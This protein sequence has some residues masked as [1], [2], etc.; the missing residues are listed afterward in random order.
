MR[1]RK[2]SVG[3]TRLIL[4]VL[5]T[6]AWAAPKYKVL[7]TFTGGSD[8][9]NPYAGPI[10]DAS[11]NL[12]GTTF[13]GGMAGCYGGNGCGVV[14][15][16]TPSGSG[17]TE[18]VLYAFSGDTDG[19]NPEASLIFDSARNLYGVTNFG[20]VLGGTCNPYG[21]GIAFELTPTSNGWTETVLYDLTETTGQNPVDGLIFDTSGN[22]WG[23]G[24]SGGRYNVGAVFELSQM[25]EVWNATTAF[26][27][28]GHDNAGIE[29]IAGM[30]LDGGGN[31]YGTTSAGG[32]HNGG[33]VFEVVHDTKKVKVLYD[34][35]CDGS[36]GKCKNGDGGHP[37]AGLVFDKKDNLYGTTRSGG[38]HGYGTVFKLAPSSGGVWKE[39]V[40]YSFSGGS[41]GANP[42]AGLVFTLPNKLYGTTES[43]GSKTAC[44][45]FGCGTVFELTP[46]SSGQWKE[47]ILHRFNGSDGREP[48]LGSLATDAAG[49]LYGT[50]DAG[51]K[52]GCFGGYGCGVVFEITP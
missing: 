22:L 18:K 52:A 1:C 50:A 47:T 38:A 32:L 41:D 13:S 24:G 45:G 48:Y 8:G 4:A 23:T 25:G 3:L 44:E 43:G 6:G 33:A 11:R 51:G 16:L 37:W 19:Q 27:F 34:F 7:Y 15:R 10:L 2:I 42:Y 12:Y 49:H 9:A 20:G 14:F 5:V 17:W 39:T 35:K 40:I 30:I 31:L 28:G 36:G 26:S 21:C 46:S 29:P